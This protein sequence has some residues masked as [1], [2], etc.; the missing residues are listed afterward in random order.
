M[1][2][3]IISIVFVICFIGGLVHLLVNPLYR[4][5]DYNNNSIV[6]SETALYN[7]VDFLT[8][9]DIQRDS[10]NIE[11]LNEVSE[12]IYD[13]FEAN[14]CDTVKYQTFP[15]NNKEYKNVICIIEGTL[16]S[17]IVLGAHY[18][19][20]GRHHYKEHSDQILRGADDNASGVAGLLE[21]SKLLGENK[22]NL[23]HTIELVA[24]TLE[25]MP[26]FNKKSMGSYIHAQD[27]FSKNEP[28]E[29]MISL[30]MIGYFSPEKIQKFPIGFLK[31][32]YPE[33][34]DFIALVAKIEQRGVKQ[35]KKS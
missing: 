9:G 25:E 31:Y 15:V 32:I 22:P 8:K 2:K 17:K 10:E 14:S 1:K 12:Y 20:D 24:Y 6:V 3:I 23:E 16:P 13:H 21:L 34:G 4:G 11:R 35:I 29:F 5:V 19:V 7:H 30:E 28:V 26:H 33:T 27:I 18:D